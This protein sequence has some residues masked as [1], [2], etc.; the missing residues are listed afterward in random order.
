MV[1]APDMPAIHMDTHLASAGPL[2]DHLAGLPGTL[3]PDAA[4]LRE[5]LLRWDRRMAADNVEAAAYAPVR[6]AVVRRLA[7]H[8]AFAA[9]AAA[10]AYPE[11]FRPW[12]SL[13]VRIGFALEH[14]LRAEELY[15]VDRTAIVREALEEAAGAEFGWWG[16]RHRL[17]AW[18]A[19]EDDEQQPLGRAVR[20]V[21]GGRVGP[22]PR[23]TPPVAQGDLVPVV[24]DWDLV[25]KDRG[26][27]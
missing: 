9:L 19:V 24:T 18:R 1:G 4:D 12:L 16:D 2:L 14:L 20:G 15:G 8:P 6:G 17:V 21:G 5:R 22:S 11:V 13:T 10:P 27:N 23:P 3:A 7:A 25:T 26:E